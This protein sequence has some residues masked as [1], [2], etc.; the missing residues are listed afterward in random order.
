MIRSIRRNKMKKLAYLALA[1]ISV[2]ALGSC[3][4]TIT[5]GTISDYGDNYISVIWYG[6]SSSVTTYDPHNWYGNNDALIDSAT[7][8]TAQNISDISE[9]WNLTNTG[10]F[11][12]TYTDYLNHTYTVPYTIPTN[13]STS[14][15]YWVLYLDSGNSNEGLYASGTEPNL[16]V[17]T[18]K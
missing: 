12:F 6:Y 16:S 13:T 8:A 1:L 11:S 10:T 5:P 3:K 14:D 15:K 2:L 4:V 18:A 7:T 17:G 9:S